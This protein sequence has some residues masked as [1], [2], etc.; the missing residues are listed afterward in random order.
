MKEI[1]I[2]G[3]DPMTITH[4]VLD[5]N[6]TL[7]VD[8]KPVDGVAER[9]DILSKDLEVHVITADT[10]GCVNKA[11]ENVPCSVTVLPPG[12]QDQAKLDVVKALGP[13]NTICI[14]N[15]RNDALML[16]E[17][18]LGFAVILGEGVSVA[19]LT[20]ADVVCTSITDA[21]DLLIH[22]LRLTASLRC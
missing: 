4:L 10:F 13:A 19:A 8:G 11:M 3:F 12:R 16:K 7:A 9:L 2:P 20:S 22:P 14:G 6:G 15:G 17:A 5:Y 18:A 1:R 21:L